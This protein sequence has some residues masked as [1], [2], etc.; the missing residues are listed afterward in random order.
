MSASSAA[1]ATAPSRSRRTSSPARAPLR[2]RPATSTAASSSFVVAGFPSPRQVGAAGSFYVMP[3]DA[4]GNW[5]STFTGTVHFTSSDPLATL[6][7]PYTFTAAD[8]G[9]HWFNATFWTAGTQSLTATDT[10]AATGSQGNI[11]VI[12]ASRFVVTGFPSSATVGAAATFSVSAVDIYGNIVPGYRGTVHFSSS[13]AAATLPGNYAFTN[14]V[15]TF[16]AT[17]RTAG[18]QSLTVTDTLSPS[19]T[20]S[21]AGIRVIP[22]ASLTGPAAGLPNQTLTFTLGAS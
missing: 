16:T 7:A 6:P 2:W 10:A 1:T 4:F 9:S 5:V 21:E 14:G 12:T 11:E 17:L 18:T 15:L 8:Y 3:Q 13:D 22:L 19:I 20:G